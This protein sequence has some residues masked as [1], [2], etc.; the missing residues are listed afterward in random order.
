M[1]CTP[2]LLIGLGSVLFAAGVAFAGGKR[3]FVNEAD[4]GQHWVATYAPN[5]APYPTEIADRSRDVCVSIGYQIDK[6]GKQ[7][8]Y[9]VLRGWY[10]DKP[11]V[12]SNVD[13]AFVQMAAGLI[14]MWK[15][16]PSPQGPAKRAL[17]TSSS[18]I[19]VG[20]KKSDPAAIRSHCQI[21]DLDAHI[22]SM[23]DKEGNRGDMN[24]EALE[25]QRRQQRDNSY[26]PHTI[27]GK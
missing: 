13:D 1:K 21:A 12:D 5:V 27:G 22:A 24:R 26:T 11:D 16:A 10:S 15:F 9:V 19:F 8:G 14:S 7:G 4:L 20:N 2:P 6:N 25:R 3:L 18:I 17:F 23:Q